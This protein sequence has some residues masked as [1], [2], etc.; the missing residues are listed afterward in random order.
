MYHQD[1][2]EGLEPDIISTHYG[3]HGQ[4]AIRKSHQSGAGHPS[5]ED[6]SEDE[7]SAADIIN[8]R[9]R[10]NINE[11]IIYVPPHQSPFTNPE[12]EA[13]FIRMLDNVIDHGFIPDGFG[14]TP[15][16]WEDGYYPVFETIR[17]GRR[18]SKMLE[19][20]LVGEVWYERACLWCQAVVCLAH[21]PDSS[22]LD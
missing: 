21:L 12:E 10:Q 6:L 14:L 8:Q 18:R 9:E 4:P 3:V 2:C 5:D 7:N 15:N 19:V 11:D 17:L 13:V 22:E 20:S 16:E 1:D